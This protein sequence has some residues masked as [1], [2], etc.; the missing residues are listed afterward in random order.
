MKKLIGIALITM[1][2]TP[3]AWA[4]SFCD[5]KDAQASVYRL[6]VVDG[7]GKVYSGGSFVAIS[8]TIAITAAHVL[9]EGVFTEGA[10]YRTVIVEDGKPGY[11]DMPVEVIK[12]DDD[13]DLAIIRGDFDNYLKM[14]E[15]RPEYLSEVIA[16]GFPYGVGPI[17]TEGKLQLRTQRQY[18]TTSPVTAGNSGGGLLVCEAGEYKLL[19]IVIETLDHLTVSVTY[20]AVM[21]FLEGVE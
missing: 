19:G 4:F 20:M 1:L 11:I 5:A 7:D 15:S 14:A 18:I 21:S 17:V 9:P 2:V 6:A 16:I 10:Y 12:S 13:I 3:A 8:P